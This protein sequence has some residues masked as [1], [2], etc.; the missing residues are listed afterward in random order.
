MQQLNEAQRS[1]LHS[2]RRVAGRPRRI[3]MLV[4]AVLTA[5][6]AS[7]MVPAAMAAD[8]GPAA[9]PPAGW[10]AVP[11]DC[12]QCGVVEAVSRRGGAAGPASGVGALTG[13]LIGGL[14]ARQLADGDDRRLLGVLGAIGGGLIGHQIEKHQRRAGV[15]V[16]L[17]M[18]DGS[19]R[20]VQQPRLA[21]ELAPAVGSWVRIDGDRLVA[22]APRT[23]GTPALPRRAAPAQ[24]GEDDAA[25]RV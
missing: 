16:T 7:T 21:H 10:P 12:S 24:P 13:A 3:R 15:E 19:R 8:D 22:L 18:V 11:A 1:V 25:R 17:R 2:G 23:S 14:L 9:R 20:V 4:A 6:L 5:A